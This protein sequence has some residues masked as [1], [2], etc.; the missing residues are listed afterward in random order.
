MLFENRKQV[1]AEELMLKYA[2]KED[3]NKLVKKPSFEVEKSRRRVDN[4]NGGLIKV[5]KA[6]GM[7]S[8]FMA[9]DPKTGLKTEIRYADSSNPKIVGD[10]VIDQFEPR[11]VNTTGATFAFQNNIDLGV[12]IYLNPNNALSPLKT[13]NGKA[14]YEFIDTKKR[15]QAKIAS[16]DALTDALSHA[17]NLNEERLVI[18]AKGLGIKGV[19][20]KDPSDVRADVMEYAS[21]YPK[22][23]NEKSNT[24][25]TYIDGR[26]TNLIDK[27]VVKLQTIGNVRRWS[28][29][30]GEREGE[31]ILDIQNVTQDAKQ[32]LKN[33]FFS[34]INKHMNILTSITNDLSAMEKAER[35]LR[36]MEAAN[37]PA[38][39]ISTERVVG[40]E[41]PDHLKNFGSDVPQTT[42]KKV[43][44][45]DDAITALQEEAGNDEMPHFNKIKAWLRRKNEE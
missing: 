22:A 34:D 40:D 37:Q 23:Y 20:K 9:T 39:V 24:E 4:I 38:Q 15:S 6:S 33:Y 31:H 2:S 5:P 11:Y 43:Y 25:L 27:G 14:K 17:K 8:H 3:Y 29:V 32:A 18:L 41:L 26:I 19:D 28:W 12:F 10:R 1:S 36:Y 44:T 7:R 35:D 30:S 21:K 45:S 16:I 42:P 13:K